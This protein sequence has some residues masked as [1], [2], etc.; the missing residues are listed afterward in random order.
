M[1]R[2]DLQAL[3]L[4]V[5]DYRESSAMVQFF[6]RE[7]GR[8]TGVMRGMRRARGQSGVQ[9]FCLGSLSISGRSGLVTVTQFEITR[10]FEL[11]EDALNAGLYV[12]ELLTRGL[13]EHQSE[14]AVFD[15]T[16]AALAGLEVSGVRLAPLLRRFEQDY[17]DALGYGLDYS[18]DMDGRPLRA[19]LSYI[20]VPEQGFSP[21]QREDGIPGS[22]L[23]Q[24]AAGNF[25]TKDVQRH[26]RHLHRQALKQVVGDKPLISPRLLRPSDRHHG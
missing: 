19:E 11:H 9:P 22:A 5:R 23:V 13:A 8:L 20:W 16:L 14:P 15:R 12:L 10:R 4:H 17:L 21:T 3:V 24:I 25:D 26:A 18:Q 1:R 6:T 2:G 7:E